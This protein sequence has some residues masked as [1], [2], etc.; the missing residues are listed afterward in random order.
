MAKLSKVDAAKAT[1]VSRQTL[2][3][4]LKDGRLS[5]DADGLIDTAELLCAG[6]TLHTG[7]EIG[8]QDHGQSGQPLTSRLDTLDVYLDMIALLKQQLT[9]AQAREHAALERAKTARGHIALQHHGDPVWF[10]HLSLR[11]LPDEQTVAL[12]ATGPA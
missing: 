1:G 8:R 5:A 12:P 11:P 6:F 9:E 2:Y 4:Y 7:H 10:R 3:T